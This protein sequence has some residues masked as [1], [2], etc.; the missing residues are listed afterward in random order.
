MKKFLFSKSSIVFT[1]LF[2]GLLLSCGWQVPKKVSIK[3]DAEFNASLG[4]ASL[5]VSE[6][7]S[8]EALLSKAKEAL[9]TSVMVY[10][11]QRD[12]SDDTLTLL[13]HYPLMQVPF[14]PSTYLS[15]LDMDNLLSSSAISDIDQTISIPEI[16]KSF[17]M[18]KSVDDAMKDIMDKATINMDPQTIAVKEGLPIGN[19]IPWTVTVANPYA[20]AVKY[21]SGS[22]MKVIVERTDS[23]A[24]SSDFSVTVDLTVENASSSYTYKYDGYSVSDVDA[25]DGCTVY[26]P[27]DKG[28]IPPALSLTADIKYIG[29]TSLVSHTYKITTAVTEDTSISQIINI[30]LEGDPDDDSDDID[31]PVVEIAEQTY[32]LTSLPD[33]FIKAVVGEG[34]I[35]IGAPLPDGWSGVSL[36]LESLTISGAGLSLNK[37]DFTSTGTSGKLISKTADL[38][39]KT[40]STTSGSQVSIS[41]SLKVNCDGATVDLEKGNVIDT[42]TDLA[43]TKF[44]QVILDLS[45]LAFSLDSSSGATIDPTVTQYLKKINFE[46]YKHITDTTFETKESDGF[47]IKCNVVNS[48]P[49]GNSIPLTVTSNIFGLTGSDAITGTIDG[50]GSAST[51]MEKK[52]NTWNDIDVKDGTVDFAVTFGA[53]GTVD[54]TAYKSIVTLNDIAA[55]SDYNLKVSDVELL[56]DWDSV[57]VNLGDSSKMDGT[58]D[59][60]SFSLTDMLESFPFDEDDLKKIKFEKINTFFYAQRPDSSGTLGS[61]IGDEI[62]IVGNMSVSYKDSSGLAKNDFLLGSST[63]SSEEVKFVDTLPWPGDSSVTELTQENATDLISYLDEGKTSFYKDI[64]TILNDYPSDLVMNYKLGISGGSNIE[65]YSFQVESAKSEGGTNISLDLVCEIPLKLS[66]TGELDLDL[67][68]LMNSGDSSSETSSSGEST[69]TETDLLGREDASTWADFADYA[70]SIKYFRLTYTITNDVLEGFEGKV[71]LTDS[72]SGLNKEALF[73]SGTQ[74]IDLTGEEIKQIMTTWPFNPQVR[75]VVAEGA[76]EA[77]PSTFKFL[78]SGSTSSDSLKANVIATVKMDKDTPITV[79]QN[80][81]SSSEGGE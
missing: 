61:L 60:S 73:A 50:T 26:I 66:L 3:T 74:T 39:G 79:W 4:K 15:S 20:E 41:G 37:D 34:S 46:Q 10:D 64:S 18:S 57:E 31:I 59:L 65:L 5:D 49:E 51:V 56:C 69:A 22:Q 54:G 25:T 63:D 78:R 45:S 40:I 12:A 32:D 53:E 11:L 9:G 2:A 52:F 35:S 30:N 75:V 80:S 29:G 42:K 81:G 13:A 48:L 19:S 24:L 58:A 14:D 68:D 6:Y 33:T 8:S 28:Y 47:G 38:G 1:A 27:L 76:T 55:G 70:E 7:V 71:K 67:K 43:I 17:D 44:S 77:S 36:D 16:T 23:N 72:A 21:T 62:K